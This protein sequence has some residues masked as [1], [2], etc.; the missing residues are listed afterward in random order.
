MKRV[1]SSAVVMAG[2]VLTLTSVSSWAGPLPNNDG[3]DSL[4]ANTAGGSGALFEN[5][6]GRFNIVSP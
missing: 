2:F 6:T 4:L 1:I 3:S 5:T